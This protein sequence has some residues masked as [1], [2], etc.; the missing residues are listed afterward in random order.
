[1][2]RTRLDAIPAV[3]TEAGHKP[4]PKLPLAVVV[5]VVVGAFA[6]VAT[7]PDAAAAR[8]AAE[9]SRGGA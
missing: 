9:S 4:H 3:K 5:E 8:S 7:M 6:V 1:L 2:V